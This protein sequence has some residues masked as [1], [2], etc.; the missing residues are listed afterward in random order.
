[1]SEIQVESYENAEWRYVRLYK[2]IGYAQALADINKLGELKR[3]V[4]TVKD[5]KG[6]LAVTWFEKPSE[7]EMHVLTHAWSSST[8]DGADNVLHH[9]R[10][11][12]LN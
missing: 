5:D 8:G 3:K 6:D 4:L 9:F 2:V 12:Q 7:M 10:G 11:E 1:M